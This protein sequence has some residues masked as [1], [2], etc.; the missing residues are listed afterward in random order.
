MYVD[1]SSEGLCVWFEL[2]VFLGLIGVTLRNYHSN[3]GKKI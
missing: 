3:M 1:A 2:I